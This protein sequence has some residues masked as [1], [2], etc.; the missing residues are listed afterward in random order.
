MNEKLLAHDRQMLQERSRS[1]SESSQEASRE[2]SEP[3]RTETPSQDR[4]YLDKGHE[5]IP[6]RLLD[7]DGSHLLPPA[8][9]PPAQTLNQYDYD[10]PHAE[11][12][13][14]MNSHKPEA[15]D[16]HFYNFLHKEAAPTVISSLD[17]EEQKIRQ[18]RQ[19]G[20]YE[21]EES[22][23]DNGDE[24]TKEERHRQRLLLISEGP[25]LKARKSRKK[26]TFLNMFRLTTTDNK[27]GMYM[28]MA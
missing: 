19:N 26:S 6:A 2:P 8:H 17:Y 9:L 21:S 10:R 25:P 24:F 14:M 27:K 22:D 20:T 3:R 28:L 13:F 4:V 16:G 1:R 23:S 15:K 5:G 18:A 7:N 12:N 11:Y